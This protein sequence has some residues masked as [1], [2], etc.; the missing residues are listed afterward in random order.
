MIIANATG[1][2]SIYGSTF[3]TTPYTTNEEG[4]GPAWANSLFEDNAEFGYGMRLAV[5]KK[6]EQLFNKLKEI[7][8]ETTNDKLKEF[9]KDHLELWEDT[10]EKAKARVRII[11][12]FLRE[13]GYETEEN[14]SLFD[15]LLNKSVWIIGGDGWAYD[16]GFNGLDHVLSKGEDVN[17]LVLDNEQYANTGGQMSKAT[18]R[19]ARAGFA[20]GGKGSAKKDLG[21]IAMNYENVFVATIDIGANAQQA[22]NAIAQAEAHKGPS[23]I[24]AYSACINHGFNMAEA[25]NHGLLASQTGQWPI[26]IENPDLKKITIQSKKTKEFNI[27]KA[28]IIWQEQKML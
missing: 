26:Y 11:R 7:L 5:D 3:P 1:C 27:R 19:G 24:I 22:I 20:S 12:H 8:S 9:L 10:D 25:N 13:E 15:Y 2:S 14:S 23:I 21:S 6:R 18:P 28:V 17:I 4:L 16:I